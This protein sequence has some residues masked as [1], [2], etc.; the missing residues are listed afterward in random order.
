MVNQNLFTVPVPENFPIWIKEV[1]LN[2]LRDSELEAYKAAMKNYYVAAIDFFEKQ[3]INISKENV[4]RF[5]DEIVRH[6]VLDDDEKQE[7]V[8]TENEPEKVPNPKITPKKK[9]ACNKIAGIED[10][11]K[12]IKKFGFIAILVIVLVLIFK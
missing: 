3:K 2:D 1:F 5:K 7:V 8:A 4:R 9:C 11:V 6:I 12:Q 10:E